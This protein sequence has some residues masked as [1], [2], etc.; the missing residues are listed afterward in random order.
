MVISSSS[1]MLKSRP[2]GKLIYNSIMN[3]PYVRRMIPEPGD[4][5]RENYRVP[6]GQRF[7]KQTDMNHSSIN[8]T[9]GSKM[10]KL[11]RPFF[12]VFLKTSM[13]LLIVV[14]LLRKSG[15]IQDKP[16]MNMA[17]SSN[18][19][20]HQTKSTQHHQPTTTRR[21]SSNPR[22]LQIAQPIRGVQNIGNGNVVAARAEGNAP[23]NNGNQIR[24]YNCRGLGHLARNCTVRPRRRDAAYLQT[25]LLI[26]QK[27]E[28][29]NPTPS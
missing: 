5:D 4:T 2:N 14:K 6:G 28:S 1:R 27:E 21:I 29:R 24:C 18:G 17:L 7:M 3:G 15:Y 23:G 13:L 8:E 16:A 9:D 22:N 19:L 26:A 10:I 11:F 25:Q 20:R 12:S